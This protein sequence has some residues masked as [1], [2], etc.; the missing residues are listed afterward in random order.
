MRKKRSQFP[1]K[2][3]F[4]FG[5]IF[6]LIGMAVGVFAFIQ[7]YGWISASSWEKVPMTIVSTDLEAHRDDDATTYKVV[8]QFRYSYNGQPF[9]ND[10][11]SFSSGSDNIGRFHQDT[12]QLLRRHLNG[13]PFTGYVNPKKPEKSVLIRKM[14]WGMFAFTLLFSILFG[15]VGLGIMVFSFIG[16]R[17]QQKQQTFINNHPDREWQ[18]DKKWRTNRLQCSNKGLMWFTIVFA[19][20]WNLVSI[21][22]AFIVPGEV[23]DKHNYIALVGLLFPLIG[24]GL[25][26]WAIR[27]VS[28]WRKFGRSIFV[29][30][31]FPAHPG[32]IVHGILELQ[33]PLHTQA[34][35]VRLSCIRKVTTGSGKNRR[36]KETFLWQD[37]Q[38]I[39]ITSRQNNVEFS[40]RLNQDA[41]L[42]DNSDSSD[43][44]LWRIDCSADVPGVDFSTNFEV[45]VITGQAD[46]QTLLAAQRLVEQQTKQAKLTDEWKQTGAQLNHQSGYPNYLFAAGR[47]KGL[48]ASLGSFGL[49]F[50]AIGAAIGHYGEAWFIG[51]VFVL[52]G[53]L[54]LWG[55]VY[56]LFNSS[57][58]IV[59]PDRIQ[60]TS[61]ILFKKQRTYP[62]FSIQSIALK[63][64]SRM[65]NT[66]YWSIILKTSQQAANNYSGRK[67][68][69][70][71]K[72]TLAA[73]IPNRR[74]AQALID[75]IK[76]ECGMDQ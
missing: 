76:S 1:D 38:T 66:Q 70:N 65:G 63:A 71:R 61:G 22:I 48:S 2:F 56:F 4:I 39:A 49:L 53:L 62:V 28:K 75:K 25:I 41:A 31:P 45:P 20:I 27:S 30:D 21:P 17:K 5:L 11:V 72:V 36:T 3:L 54:M 32:G 7:L 55:T 26:V 68:S 9:E 12:Y 60:V 50:A 33:S 58:F 35:Q 74:A 67:P 64:G 59:K 6:F 16:K 73:D 13:E 37:E 40:F 46:E 19:A 44:L 15:G 52:F 51:G 10:K 34:L 24:I 14:R 23:F 57:A 43:Q 29:M 47:N 8:A 18:A 69:K 42:S